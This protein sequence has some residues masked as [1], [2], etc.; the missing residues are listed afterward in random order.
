MGTEKVSALYRE[1][2]ERAKNVV[3]DVA[4]RLSPS[5]TQGREDPLV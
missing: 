1:A 5:K 2:V 4:K 3:V